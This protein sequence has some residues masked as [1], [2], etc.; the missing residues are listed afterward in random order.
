MTLG[1]HWQCACCS[2]LSY[3]TKRLSVQLSSSV[4][5]KDI[6]GNDGHDPLESFKDS[7]VHFY[8]PTIRY[9]LLREG[10]QEASLP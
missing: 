10:H 9:S 4:P 5:F 1:R 2:Y 3:P 6:G 8:L 7:A